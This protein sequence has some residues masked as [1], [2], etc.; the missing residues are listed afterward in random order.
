MFSTEGKFVKQ[1]AKHVFKI[2]RFFKEEVSIRLFYSQIFLKK[3]HFN[4]K[5]CTI[6]E[7]SKG[8]YCHISK[9]G[10]GLLGV[11]S[12]LL[13]FCGILGVRETRRV[14]FCQI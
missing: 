5:V 2:Y 9:L 4:L 11:V 3:I 6:Q 14:N 7:C 8:W 13:Q 12:T 1:K 10:Q